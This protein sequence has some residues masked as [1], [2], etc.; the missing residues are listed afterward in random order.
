MKVKLSMIGLM[1]PIVAISSILL[2]VG[3]VAVWHAH[4]TQRSVSEALTSS[5]DRFRAAEELAIR[6]RD[7]GADCQRF[8]N[9]GNRNHF[10]EI[11]KARTQTDPWLEK[12]E[13]TAPAPH[14]SELIT[15]VKLGYESFFRGF[16]RIVNAPTRANAV[17]KIEV[18]KL[19]RALASESQ[20]PAQEYL[21]FIEVEIDRLTTEHRQVAERTVL[22]LLLLGICGPIAGLYA[23]YGI[24]RQVHRSIV[25]LSVAVSDAA[26]KLEGVVGPLTLNRREGLEALETALKA[27]AE[28]VG[29]VVERLQQSQR[30]ALHSKQLATLGQLAAGFAH[31]LRNGLMPMKILVQAAMKRS[32]EPCLDG[33]DL[34]VLDQ[35][36]TRLERSIQTLLDFARPPSPTKKLFDVRDVIEETVSVLSVRA[37][38]VGVEIDVQLPLEPVM[39]RADVGQIRQVVLNLVLNALDAVSAEGTVLVELFERPGLGRPGIVT[40]RVSDTGCGLPAE[41]GGRIFEPFVSTKE[42]GVGLGLSICKRIVDDHGGT[43]G[44]ADR[45]GGGAL[46]TVELPGILLDSP[47]P[48]PGVPGQTRSRQAIEA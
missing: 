2:T 3:V 38:L 40:L 17:A 13:R 39:I 45:P 7:I 11:I 20:Q 4:Y 23:G 35:E 44:A 19:A 43:I 22:G 21:D 18:E 10:D 27:I 26:G 5:I 15:R 12:N 8:V 42:T 24:A 1:L 48:G 28:R 32:P 29:S 6:I 30:E 25:R 37:R 34:S 31:E 46:F 9:D 33:P 36:I 16:D 14:G 47:A 41:L